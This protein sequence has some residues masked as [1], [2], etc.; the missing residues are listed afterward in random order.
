MVDD[1]GIHLQIVL[2]EEGQVKNHFSFEENENRIQKTHEEA[3]LVCEIP[4]EIQM[5]AVLPNPDIHVKPG[6]VLV[7]HQQ[8]FSVIA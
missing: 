4:D 6:Q 7:S 3:W 1:G 5:K 8:E 2:I